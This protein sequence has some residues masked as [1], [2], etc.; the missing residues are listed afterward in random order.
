MFR[1]KNQAEFF[2]YNSQS[3]S[4]NSDKPS[5]KLLSKI[6]DKLKLSEK[7][8]AKKDGNSGRNVFGKDGATSGERTSAGYNEGNL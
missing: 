8:L 1:K 4:L 7:N 5:S 2:N 6:H 3:Y